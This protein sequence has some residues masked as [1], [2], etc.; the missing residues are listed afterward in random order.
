MNMDQLKQEAG[1]KAA[2]YFENDMIVGLGTGS[3]AYHTIQKTAQRI[4]EEGLKIQAVSTSFFTTVLC[5]ELNIP[6]LTVDQISSI[7]VAVDGADEITQGKAL[8]KGRGA[9]HTQ[10]KIVAAL[11]HEFLVVADNSKKVDVLGSKMPVPVE[12]MGMALAPVQTHL[13]K[14]GGICKL[15]KAD[16]CKDGPC[17][18]DNGNLIFDVT[19]GSIAD[20]KELEKTI[21]NIPGVL[22]N[23]LFP[24]YATKIILASPEGVEEW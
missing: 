1:Y 22:D 16:S 18:T 3:T 14:L 23:G 15:R 2:G 7:D 9:A 21:N 17:I 4:K 13:E 11:S 6:L 20:A 5:R 19:F 8:I 12:F 10:E 24:D